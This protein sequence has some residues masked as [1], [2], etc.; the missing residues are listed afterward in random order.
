M[1]IKKNTIIGIVVALL[2]AFAAIFYFAYYRKFP[3][4]NG[5]ESR[6]FVPRWKAILGY[7][8]RESEY[9]GGGYIIWDKEYLFGDDTETLTEMLYGVK[10]VSMELFLSETKKYKV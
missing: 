4:K 3:L 10:E 5:M 9:S 7:K 1:K 8:Y 6:F 2:V